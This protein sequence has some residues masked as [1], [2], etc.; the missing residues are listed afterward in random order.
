M[1]G[2]LGVEVPGVVVDYA[3]GFLVDVFFEGLAAEEGAVAW[4]EVDGLAGFGIIGLFGG[5]PGG[6]DF[7]VGWVWEGVV[8]TLEI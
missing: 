4:V 1:G 6:G 5:K 7:E 2:G 8:P 3:G